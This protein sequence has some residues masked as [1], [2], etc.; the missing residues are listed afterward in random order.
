MYLESILSTAL[1]KVDICLSRAA[2]A[3]AVLPDESE[4]RDDWGIHDQ[5]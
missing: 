5:D 3:I 4:S 1:A 2:A